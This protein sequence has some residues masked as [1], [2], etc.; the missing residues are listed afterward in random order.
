MD[1]KIPVIDWDKHVTPRVRQMHSSAI[2]E[3]FSQPLAH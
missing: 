3:I 2:R 1:R